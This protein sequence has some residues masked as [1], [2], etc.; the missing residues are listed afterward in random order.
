MYS[1]MSICMSASW[2]PNICAA[3]CLAV[4][5]L[6][7]P[8]GPDEQERADRPARI[9]QVRARAPQRAGDGAGG[10]LLADHDLLELGLEAEELLALLL[11][12]ARERDAGPVGDHL[13]HQVLVDRDALLL[14]GL[15]PLLGHLLLP[16]RAAASP[17][18]GTWR[19][20]RNAAR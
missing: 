18:R 20:P 1:L 8:V 9:L 7:T 16:A 17:C 3:S 4:S 11:L 14:A 6:P 12:H 10:D 13:H 5:V 15:L 2:L 19:P